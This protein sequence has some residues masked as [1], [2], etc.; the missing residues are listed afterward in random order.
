M[1]GKLTFSIFPVS[2]GGSRHSKI[3]VL[4]VLSEGLDAVAVERVF[5][6]FH[7]VAQNFGEYAI[8]GSLRVNVVKA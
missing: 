8:V 5:F 2:S 7:V 3:T 1:G 6:D 4:D